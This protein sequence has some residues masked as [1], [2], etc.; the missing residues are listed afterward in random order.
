V[1]AI[2]EHVKTLVLARNLSWEINN[3][4]SNA[5]NERLQ[6]CATKTDKT[7]TTKTQ[8]HVFEEIERRV[9]WCYCIGVALGR[10]RAKKNLATHTARACVRVRT[11]YLYH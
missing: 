7:T 6:R 9:N 2:A 10:L 1:S 5:F 8:T 3:K 11:I 4:V